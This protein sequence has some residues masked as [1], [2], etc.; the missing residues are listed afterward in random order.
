MTFEI[1]DNA[2]EL[3]TC[4]IH[5]QLVTYVVFQTVIAGGSVICSLVYLSLLV[6]K[7]SH[8]VI[9]PSPC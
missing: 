2:V 5:L 3:I 8:T 6:G 9:S 1:I 4:V 7:N